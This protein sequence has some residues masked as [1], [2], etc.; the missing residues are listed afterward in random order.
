M[1]QPGDEP[2]AHAWVEHE[3]WD[4]VFIVGLV[5]GERAAFTGPRAEYDRVHHVMKKFRYS[6]SEAIS[7]NR[8]TG[9]YGPWEPALEKLCGNGAGVTMLE[10]IPLVRISQ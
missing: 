3:G 4:Q 7:E 6:Y 1:I 2:S 9:T 5:E 8:R 10:P